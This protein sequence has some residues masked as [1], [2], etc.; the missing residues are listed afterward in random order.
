[1]SDGFEVHVAAFRVP[2]DQRCDGVTYHELK[3]LQTG[4]DLG[5]PKEVLQHSIAH[6]AR[7]TLKNGLRYGRAF[8]RLVDA[9]GPD[10]IHAHQS[11][12]F[13]WYAFCGRL[14][15]RYK[16]AFVVSTWGTDV[17]TYPE[18]SVLFRILNNI[19]LSRAKVITATSQHL[20]KATRRWTGQKNILVIPFGVD[21]QLFSKKTAI[22]DRAEVFGMAK[23]LRFVGGVDI[24]GFFKAIR[25]LKIARVSCPYMRLEIAGSGP[26][27][28]QLKQMV[29]AL[30]LKNAVTFLGHRE[31]SQIADTMRR[32]DV[33]LLPSER[34]SFGVVAV[35]ALSIGLPVVGSAIDGI[36]EVIESGQTGILLKDYT[37]LQLAEAMRSVNPA[38]QQ[39]AHRLGPEIA[40][41]RFSWNESVQKMRA[42]YEALS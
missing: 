27:E 2:P 8:A 1:M 16:P 25:A 6:E 3:P 12:P 29:A 13:G 5:A 7:L 26:E 41:K 35:E 17:V 33:L 36:P 28:A 34:E 19:V 10:I 20:A 37:P 32:W 31:H 14:F 24:Y 39:R 42:V 40:A 21:T 23:Q 22:R 15:A 9:V 30:G 38:L 4:V 11:V 18:K